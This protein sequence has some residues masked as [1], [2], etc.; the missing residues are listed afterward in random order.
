[1]ATYLILNLCVLLAVWAWLWQAPTRPS[2]P[3]LVMLFGLLVLTVIFDN[4]LIALGM[5]SYAPDKILGVHVGM[6]PLE[7]FMY[8]VLAAIV[9][10]AVW[11]RTGGGRA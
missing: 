9:I 7:D 3:W 11:K 6:A 1:M 4:I 8:A 2:K 5:Y 10:P